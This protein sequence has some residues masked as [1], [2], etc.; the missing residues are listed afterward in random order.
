MTVHILAV[1]D[2][3]SFGDLAV[4]TAFELARDETAGVLHVLAISAV[5]KSVS[6]HEQLTDDLI[7]FARIGQQ[8][9]LTVEGSIL[10]TPSVERLVEEIRNRQIDHLVIVQPAGQGV[11]TT[12]SRVLEAAAAAAGVATTVVRGEC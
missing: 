11:D 1:Y 12:I 2:R 4:E 8:V 10:E 5:P 7:A 9:G 3:S 6:Q